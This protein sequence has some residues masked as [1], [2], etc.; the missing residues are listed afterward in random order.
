MIGVPASARA[1][2]WTIKDTVIETACVT[3]FV[4]DWRQ[5]LDRRYVES[6]A[7]L[8]PRPSYAAVSSYFLGITLVHLLTARLLPHPW[9]NVFQ[10]IA[11]G[12]E[13]RS[14][15]NNWLVGAR[16]GW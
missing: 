10:G 11:I 3:L 6:N 7:I 15:F 5:S 2:E 13:G 8:G 4:V 12:I 9:R 16:L 14:V 1:D